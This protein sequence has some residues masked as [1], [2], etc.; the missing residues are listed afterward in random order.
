MDSVVTNRLGPAELACVPLDKGF[1]FSSDVKV[2]I[3]PGIGLANLGVAGLDQQP[4]PLTR[5]VTSEI[6][7]NNDP[8]VR[9]P[10]ST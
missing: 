6:E 1:G 10:V 8:A 7:L 5:E 4:V 2:F 9:Q 3:Q